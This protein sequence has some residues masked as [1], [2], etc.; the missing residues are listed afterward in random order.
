MAAR[1]ALRALCAVAV[2]VEAWG[3]VSGDRQV[4]WVATLA[5]LAVIAVHHVVASASPARGEQR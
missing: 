3:A 2:G 1:W 4:L 5:A